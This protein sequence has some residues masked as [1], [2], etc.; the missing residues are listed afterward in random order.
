MGL[1]EI[2]SWIQSEQTRMRDLMGQ[3][4]MGIES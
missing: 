4:E 2:M 3:K 1:S